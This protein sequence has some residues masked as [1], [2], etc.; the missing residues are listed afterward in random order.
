MDYSHA[1]KTKLCVAKVVYY[2]G[3]YYGVLCWPWFIGYG[4]VDVAT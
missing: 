3:L 1:L 4:P 2:Y